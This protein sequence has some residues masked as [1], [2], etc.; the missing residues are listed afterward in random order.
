MINHSLRTY[1]KWYFIRF[2][3]YSLNSGVVQTFNFAKIQSIRSLTAELTLTRVLYRQHGHIHNNLRGINIT[4][5]VRYSICT[6]EHASCY[7]WREE[8]VAVYCTQV[9][10]LY[11]ISTIYICIIWILNIFMLVYYNIY[12]QFLSWLLCCTVVLNII[13]SSQ[14]LHLQ[15]TLIYDNIIQVHI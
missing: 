11:C 7:K 15:C 13:I 10:I 14:L 12:L 2:Q 6:A 5:F 4:I 9:Y 8:L 1:T 3:V